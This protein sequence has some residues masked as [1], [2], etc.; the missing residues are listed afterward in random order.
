MYPVEFQEMNRVLGSESEEFDSLP[1]FTDGRECISCWQMSWKE[2]LSALLFGKVWLSVKTEIHSLPATCRWGIRCL[3]QRVIHHAKHINHH[4]LCDT[5]SGFGRAAEH[6]KNL[7]DSGCRNH[8]WQTKGTL[9]LSQWVC[10]V[11]MLSSSPRV[12]TSDAG[13]VALC[14]NWIGGGIGRR[15]LNI[16]CMRVMP[17]P[18]LTACNMRAGSNPVRSTLLRSGEYVCMHLS[19]PRIKL[20]H[21]GTALRRV[22]TGWRDSH[23]L[24]TNSK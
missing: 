22:V 5:D 3:N 7:P 20:K 19:H 2:R 10:L 12:L 17:G 14:C 8:D 15:E 18:Y 13:C 4:V 11:G 16:Y 6:T 24:L 1:V 9:V 23:S 21:D